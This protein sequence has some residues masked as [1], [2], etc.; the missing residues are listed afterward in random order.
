MCKDTRDHACDAEADPDKRRSR[1]SR[2]DTQTET[3]PR[4]RVDRDNDRN[5]SDAGTAGGGMRRCTRRQ[6]PG[7]T[8]SDLVRHP[9]EHSAQSEADTRPAV[10]HSGPGPA[11]SL[12]GGGR[13][14]A[15]S[16]GRLG[17]ESRAGGL[18]G[19]LSHSGASA[20]GPPLGAPLPQVRSESV[21][22]RF[23][24]TEGG[25]GREL[26]AA[27]TRDRPRPRACAARPAPSCLLGETLSAG[28]RPR[29]SC[30]SLRPARPGPPG[31]K[32]RES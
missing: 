11:L 23:H 29:Q 7:P 16:G 26:D 32:P 27:G 24:R 18:P 28:S 12:L 3:A 30:G 14:G 25:E 19:W 21:T 20:G 15:G 2:A 4:S 5:A 10:T 6:T 22:P 17:R 9:G 1:G 13:G 8:H 31:L